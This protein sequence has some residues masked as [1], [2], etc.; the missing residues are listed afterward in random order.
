[1]SSLAIYIFKKKRILVNMGETSFQYA[2]FKMISEYSGLCHTNIQ[3]LHLCG[4]GLSEADV[5]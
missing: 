3:M 4:K 2:L 1:M 5:I